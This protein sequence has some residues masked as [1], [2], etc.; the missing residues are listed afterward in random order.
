MLN[1]YEKEK[2]TSEIIN[3]VHYRIREKLQGIEV[4]NEEELL[5]LINGISQGIITESL[6]KLKLK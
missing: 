5:M 3:E 2:F 4:R 6:I 1:D